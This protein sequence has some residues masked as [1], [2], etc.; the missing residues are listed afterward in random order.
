MFINAQLLE[1]ITDG[2][3]GGPTWRTRRVPLRSGIIRRNPLQSLPLYRFTL[4][5]QNLQAEAHEA[6]IAAFNACYG[7]VHSF[8]WKD[9]EDYEA[10]DEVLA[11]LGT[12]AEQQIQLTKAYTFGTQTVLRNIRT[13]ETGSVSMTANGSP[14]AASINYSTGI[15][16]LTAANGAVLR[17][18]GR[19]HVPVMFEQDE[20]P[21]AGRNIGDDRRLLSGDVPLIE[22]RSV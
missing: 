22:D 10:D 18:S 9:W 16:T 6:I 19:F 11:V 20:L 5:Y 7:G 3:S 15:A 12:G 21:F 4:Q 2:S 8:R 13:P 1:C 17:W 14:Q